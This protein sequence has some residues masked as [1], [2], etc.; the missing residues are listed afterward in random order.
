MRDFRELKVW[1]KSHALILAIYKE[2]VCFP[3]NELYGLTS[4]IRRAAVS[5]GANIA[6]GAG[7]NSRPDFA[8]FLQMS[9]GS[10]S[11]LEYELLLACDLG[12]VTS[13]KRDELINQVIETKKMLTGFIYYLNG[14]RT[15]TA[16]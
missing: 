6:E 16:A 11:E 15:G 7:K 12:Y 10:A 8:R 1:Q 2:T 3:K 13:A 4:Q 9:L 14:S 5:I